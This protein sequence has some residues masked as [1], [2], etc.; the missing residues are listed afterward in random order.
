MVSGLITTCKYA[1]V[2]E[3]HIPRYLRLEVQHFF[4]E[5]A[6]AP[7][8]LEYDTTVGTCGA[9][10]WRAA[11]DLYKSWSRHQVCMV[12]LVSFFF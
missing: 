3:P 9:G 12:T 11:A 10:G 8:S 4:P 1:H 2:H 5:V 6:G 7:V